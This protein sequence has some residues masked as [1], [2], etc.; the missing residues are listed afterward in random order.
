MTTEVGA[1]S[2]TLQLDQTQFQRDLQ[3]LNNTPISDIKAAVALDTAS[4]QQQIKSLSQDSISFAVQLDTTPLQQ[5][6]TRIRNQNY[7]AIKI[8]LIPDVSS[9]ERQLKN[10][11][12]F[13]IDS[14][15]V[16]I[17][18]D[19]QAFQSKLKDISKIQVDCLEICI[20]P[21][22]T[23]FRQKLEGIYK[24]NIDCLPI[25]LCLDA[26]EFK[27]KIDDIKSTKPESVDIEIKTDITDVT[28]K[29]NEIERTN[30]GGI[31]IQLTTD[32]SNLNS[33][34][35]S[36]YRANK[37]IVVEVDGNTSSLRQELHA[38]SDIQVNVGIDNIFD[39]KLEKSIENA[40]NRVQG[41]TF[42]GKIFNALSAPFKLLS[43]PIQSVLSGAFEGIGLGTTLPL[44]EKLGLGIATGFDRSLKDRVHKSLDEIGQIIGEASGTF[45]IT[46]SIEFGDVLAKD[47]LLY[48]D[49]LK[50]LGQDIAA[51]SRKAS[52]FL[53]PEPFFAALDKMELRFGQFLHQTFYGKDLSG[54]VSKLAEDLVSPVTNTLDKVKNL[55]GKL[56]LQGDLNN[57][58]YGANYGTAEKFKTAFESGNRVTQIA[59]EQYAKNPDA[60]KREDPKYYDKLAFSLRTPSFS[61]SVLN[62]YVEEIKRDTGF[63]EI[64]RPLNALL[65]LVRTATGPIRKMNAIEMDKL[66]DQFA[67]EYKDAIPELRPGEKGYTIYA[68]GAS[69]L[70]RGA[71]EHGPIV[72]AAFPGTRLVSVPLPEYEFGKNL[73]TDNIFKQLTQK[74]VGGTGTQVLGETGGSEAYTD[75]FSHFL[76]GYSTAG[77]RLQG[78]RKAAIAKGTAPENVQT[79]GFSIGSQFARA[80]AEGYQ[81]LGIEHRTLGIGIGELFEPLAPT[82]KNYIPTLSNE[83]SL[84]LP[85]LRGLFNPGYKQQL[86]NTGDILNPAKHAIQHV[87]SN[88]EFLPIGQKFQGFDPSNLNL[89][90]YQKNLA[91]LSEVVQA[92]RVVQMLSNVQDRADIATGVVSRPYRFSGIYK[93]EQGE[94]DPVEQKEVRRNA[95]DLKVTPARNLDELFKLGTELLDKTFSQY[96]SESESL[97]KAIQVSEENLN[98]KIFGVLTN[99]FEQLDAK[100]RDL[101]THL[102]GIPVTSIEEAQSTFATLKQAV[103]TYVEVIASASKSGADF[104]R[105]EHQIESALNQLPPS[106]TQLNQSFLELKEHLDEFQSKGFAF[107]RTSELKVEHLEDLNNLFQDKYED[108][109]FTNDLSTPIAL[110]NQFGTQNLGLNRVSVD[111]ILKELKNITPLTSGKQLEANNLFFKDA[112]ELEARLTA[113]DIKATN[114]R[115]IATSLNL[116]GVS[117]AGTGTKASLTSEIVKN[118]GATA[119]GRE[120][121]ASAVSA[122]LGHSTLFNETEVLEQ[123]KANRATLKSIID[124]IEQIDEKDRERVAREVLRLSSE[125]IQFSLELKSQ[126]NLTKASAFAGNRSQFEQISTQARA[127]LPE[128]SQAGLSAIGTDTASGLTNSLEANTGIVKQSGVNLGKAV[129]RGAKESLEIQSPSRVFIRI[130][131]FVVEGFKQGVRKFKEVINSD[132]VNQIKSSKK[133]LNN[134]ELFKSEIKQNRVAQLFTGSGD[135]ISGFKK[136]LKGEYPVFKDFSVALKELRAGLFDSIPLLGKFSKV[137][138]DLFKGFIAFQGIFILQDAL[139]SI[140][141]TAFNAYT[142][143]DRLQTA[144]NFASGSSLL[145]ANNL[146]FVRKQVEE[147]KIPLEAAIEGFTTL[148]GAAR[149]NPIQGEG[150]QELAQGTFQASTVLSLSP[151]DTQ[152]LLRA[153]TDALSRGKIDA[154]F[155]RQELSTKIPGASEIAARAMGTSL[156][157]FNKLV[158]QGQVLSEDFLPKLGKELQAEFGDAS[159]DASNNAQSAVFGLQNSF[160]FLQVEIGKAIGP[161]AMLGLNLLSG[162]L[163]LVTGSAF[164]LVTGVSAAVLALSTKLIPSLLETINKLILTRAAGASLGSG[165]QAV[166]KAINN[167]LT[168]QIGVGLFAVAEIFKQINDSIHTDLVRPMEEAVNASN[169]LV[170]A[171]NRARNPTKNKEDIS[172]ELDYVSPVDRA[173]RNYASLPG[174]AK[175]GLAA[176]LPPVGLVALAGEG[177]N[178]GVNY[179]RTGKTN[180]VSYADLQREK[181]LDSDSQIQANSASIIA[182]VSLDAAELKTGKGKGAELRQVDTALRMQEIQRKILQDRAN[183]EFTTAGKPVPA[184][185]EQ[186]LE[187]SNERIRQLTNKR[188][189]VFK[190]LNQDLGRLTNQIDIVRAQI[191]ALKSKKIQ[192][193]V[194]DG[195]T[196]QR[197]VKEQA[198][199]AALIKRKAATEELIASLYIDPV[200]HFTKAI[201]NLNLQLARTQ[202]LA[203]IKFTLA[204]ANITERQV[205]S[206]N[207]DPFGS[208]KAALKNADIQLDKDKEDLLQ[209]RKSQR[210]KQLEVESPKF[211]DTLKGYGLK[212]GST[213]ADIQNAIDVGDKAGNLSAGDKEALNYLKEYAQLR[214][215]IADK[216]KTVNTDRLQRQETVQQSTLAILERNSAIT[217]SLIQQREDKKTRII[218]NALKDR[219]IEEEQANLALAVLAAEDTQIR[220]K[221]N[222][223]Q[224]KD[225]RLALK[226]G[227]LSRAEFEKQERDLTTKGFSL[228]R[229]LAEQE[230][231]ARE[232][233]TARV[234]AFL[235]L[236]NKKVEAQISLQQTRRNTSFKELVRDARIDEPRAAQLT[237]NADIEAT[238]TR[239]ALIKVELQQTDYLEKAKLIAPKKAVEERLR[240]NQELANANDKLVSDQIEQEK[241]YRDEVDRTIGRLKAQIELESS[242]KSFVTAREN[243]QLLTAP[244]NK[245]FKNLELTNKE[246]ELLNTRSQLLAQEKALQ[247]EINLV[248]SLKLAP[249][250]KD[251]KLRQ[252]YKAQSDLYRD[253][254]KNDAEIFLNEQQLRIHAIEVEAQLQKNRNDLVISGRERE[255]AAQELLNQSFERSQKLEQSRYDLRKALSD[256]AVT[257]SQTRL[258]RV[259]RVADLRKKLDDPNVD[260]QVKVEARRQV[261]EIGI[262]SNASE[263]DFVRQKQKIEDDIAT[264]KLLAL[265][266]E[267]EFQRQSLAID[268]QRQRITA[269]TAEFEAEIGQLKAR[270]SVLDAEAKLRTAQESGDALAVAA[271]ETGL[272]IARSQLDISGKQLDNAKAQLGIQDELATNALKAQNATQRAAIDAAN[273]TEYSRQGAEAIERAEA[274]AGKTVN[275]LSKE[276]V[277][278]SAAGLGKTDKPYHFRN[279]FEESK[280]KA[281]GILPGETNLDAEL[282]RQG[283]SKRKFKDDLQALADQPFF[284]GIPDFK[285]ESSGFVSSSAVGANNLTP[286]LKAPQLQTRDDLVNSALKKASSPNVIGNPNPG[287]SQVVDGLKSANKGIED[288]LERVIDIFTLLARSPRNLTV[289]SPTPVN[290]AAKIMLDISRG[291]VVNAGLG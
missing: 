218:K 280:Y 2:I 183:R 57:A 124:Q 195:E 127:K 98:P 123:L 31:E 217:E 214:Q 144:L 287:F 12:K 157:Q 86:I 221:S 70:A 242:Q 290:D 131:E 47:L 114:L 175:F 72:Q 245:D 111:S 108:K 226:L 130:G 209:L 276:G 35:E 291:S 273:S 16:E 64:Q 49:G 233:D 231:A 91:D 208:Q 210:A 181:I 162:V 263:L 196:E 177:I 136:G 67:A 277:A 153:E 155:L 22:I 223:K 18:P 50:G 192:G 39:S 289:N 146:S 160:K 138:G 45:T 94:F 229:Q 197:I 278:T 53:H 228:R 238:K 266:S 55:F 282:R 258:D 61:T 252:L 85:V 71:E 42:T 23:S 104:P 219:K 167:S 27:K 173:T 172:T 283:K 200:T 272:E 32:T 95:G 142:S 274:A 134:P 105:I 237:T 185:I 109:R 268:L 3:S 54:A 191:E 99:T 101:V 159:V 174:E 13:N 285:F 19:L 90:S 107:R 269:T 137:V 102:T 135:F 11:P 56:D 171:S 247:I 58:T 204:Q 201:I 249:D 158:E 250:L 110:P 33:Q 96:K 161:G 60:L 156:A 132:V 139:R 140:T 121:V 281:F 143:F 149:G 262:N 29:L 227:F 179:L 182:N 236:E 147:L 122:N 129:I 43:Y 213:V 166:G 257:E 222:D 264:K 74:I 117:A 216:T 189:E 26:D 211:Q 83:D 234:L 187:L 51:I 62:Q 92:S 112:G 152:G 69:G 81:H 240:L 34:L 253:E 97:L 24:L 46:R 239:I 80:A 75:L 180:F 288:K 225:L 20:A 141:A 88:P 133:E 63:E 116:S 184:A 212:A 125:Q 261:S 5:Q 150:T 243:F 188:S 145:G 38:I 48:Q 6:I 165:L 44:G 241:Q 178:R 256:A 73:P 148:A 265:Q 103:N 255:K 89:P 52:N 36:V 115:S 28:R 78:L 76:F 126:F 251:D 119:A 79:I 220:I 100:L 224:L 270:Q 246:K 202:E 4:V 267:Q 260:D 230:L 176:L 151:E 14:I 206:F 286:I 59:A 254:V 128:V 25:E 120:Q 66:S 84:N 205:K 93:K 10:L 17:I 271:A 193:G 37:K 106:L 170:E 207:T 40:F 7:G 215:A 232:A 259:N 199:L 8:Q 154:E 198:G 275:N 77:A 186:E 30:F 15:E 21:D 68:S 169:R 65:R 194:Y 235:E 163:K 248:P 1:V 164:E 168:L 9:F 244:G 284:G 113:P 203:N 41:N 279:L 118:F 190:P 82:P 87:L